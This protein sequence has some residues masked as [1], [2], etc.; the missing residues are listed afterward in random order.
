MPRTLTSSAIAQL[1][2]TKVRP[3]FFVSMAFANETVYAWTGVGSLSWDGHTWLGVGIL[4]EVSAIVEG[5]DVSAQGITLSLSGIS[6]ELLSDSMSELMAGKLAQVYLGF[7]DTDGAL[8]ADPIPAFI[9]LIDQPTIDLS[10]DKVTISITVEN[11]LS[12]LNRA[13]GGRYT[14]QDQRARYP[15]DSSLKYVHFL[16]DEHFTWK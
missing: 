13:R 4:G 2:A 8:I 11:R 14:D 6:S 1:K 15:N 9:G 5:S 12:D 7:L 10:T 3:A 16:Q